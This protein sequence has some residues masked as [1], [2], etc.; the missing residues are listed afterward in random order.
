MLSLGQPQKE[1][2]T[3]IPALPVENS[4]KK[5][6]QARK[7]RN[8]NLRLQS[9]FTELAASA[10]EFEKSHWLGLS[11][12]M[13]ACCGLW[14]VGI[15]AS[16]RRGIASSS[17]CHVKFCPSCAA[18]RAARM[19]RRFA[20]AI[21]KAEREGHRVRFLTLTVR[22]VPLD[23]LRQAVKGLFAEWTKMRRQKLFDGLA[24]SLA[25][26][27]ITINKDTGEAHPHLHILLVGG[28]F[29]PQSEIAEAWSLLTGGSF[30]VDIRATN[31]ERLKELL[32]YQIKPT[33]I[34]SAEQLRLLYEG[35]HGVRAI[36]AT[37]CLHGLDAELED[38]EFDEELDG[39]DGKFVEVFGFYSIDDPILDCWIAGSISVEEM[40]ARSR[41]RMM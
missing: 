21:R 31:E 6:H 41:L 17:F 30:M 37:G 33:D 20:P 22:N 28:G 23:G 32:K 35:L 10:P 26:L 16:G 38:D 27:D 14:A 1:F 36:R 24:G 8:S 4:S 2:N 18:R 9:F 15:T 11:E 34:T 25:A 13:G 29:I 7:R 40:R 3:S 39:D 12:R 5:L 19:A